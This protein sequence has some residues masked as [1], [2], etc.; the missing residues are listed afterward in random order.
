[1]GTTTSTGSDTVPDPDTELKIEIA[2][3]RAEIAHGYP[4]FEVTLTKDG[5]W[6]EVYNEGELRAFLRG[7]QA[8]HA[9]LVGPSALQ[10][11]EIPET[12]ASKLV[13]KPVEA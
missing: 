4:L 13:K 3:H 9:L 10:I 5:V 11:P 12:L 7:V 1:M 2:R 8:A 6:D